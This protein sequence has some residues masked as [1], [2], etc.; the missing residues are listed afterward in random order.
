MN[1]LIQKYID[2]SMQISQQFGKS[3][4]HAIYPDNFEYYLCSFELINYYG[5]RIAFLQF[6][7]MPEAI[8]ESTTSIVTTTKTNSGI[9]S[10]FNNTFNPVNISIS[11]NFGRS[12]KILFGNKEI[13]ESKISKLFD[14]SN[15]V[16]GGWIKNSPPI[17]KTGYGL[18]RMMKSIIETSR[19]TDENDEAYCLIFRNHAFNSSYI[20]EIM[21]DTYSMN[22]Q[23]NMIWNYS[24][25][26]KAIGNANNLS[27][28]NVEDFNW[29]FM[30]NAGISMGNELTNKTLANVQIL[31][32]NSL[33][34]I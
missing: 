31:I 28:M 9:V 10:V 33:L 8:T 4:L 14:N 15:S 1:Y 29:N 17:A 22:M 34:K 26:M 19:K 21:N 25:E 12:L 11:G 30:K 23:S 13:T 24:I 6:P 3:A 7:I 32:R 5:E 2:M 20:V 16:I 18:I 27:N